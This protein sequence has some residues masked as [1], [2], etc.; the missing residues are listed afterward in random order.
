[1]LFARAEYLNLLWLLPILGGGL[2]WQLRRRRTRLHRF[3]SGTLAA[4]FIA[5]FSRGR[6]AARA[7]F[8]A[9]FFLFGILALARPQWGVRQDTLRRQGVDVVLALDT[10]FSMNAEDVAPDRLGKAKSEIRGLIRRLGGNRIG[11]VAFSG[12]AIVQC[13]LTM[14]YGAIDLFLDVADTGLIPEPGTSLAAAI[15]TSTRAFIAGERKYKALVLF[16]DGEDL[17]GQVQQSVARAREAGIVIYTI[18]VGT[19]EGKPIPIRDAKGDIMEYRK[20]PEGQIVVSRLDE[21]SLADISAGTGGRYFR[22][23][24][25]EGELDEISDE[26]LHMERKQLES[27]VFQN[28]AE[29]FQYPLALAILCLLGESWVGERRRPTAGWLSRLYSRTRPG[30]Q[31]V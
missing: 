1:M 3:V 25:G 13:P 19:T 23:T 15:Q 2:V 22:A 16:T 12:A 27:S 24:T 11:L 20:D 7:L 18:G 29:Q 31:S 5:D 21:R 26:I 10:S 4:R 9:G 6:A 8:L 17:E 28:R 30:G 14:D